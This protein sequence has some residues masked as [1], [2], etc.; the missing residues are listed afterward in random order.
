[1]GQSIAVA[2]TTL[3]SVAERPSVVWAWMT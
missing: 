1:M 2:E 3:R